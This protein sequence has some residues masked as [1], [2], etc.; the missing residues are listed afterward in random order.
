MSRSILAAFRR[1]NTFV[2]LVLIACVVAVLVLA[3]LRFYREIL[4]TQACQPQCYG[5]DALWCKE[6]GG[7]ASEPLNEGD[8]KPP[9]Y[10][11]EECDRVC[12]TT[13]VSAES[14][15]ANS[16]CFVCEDLRDEPAPVL[17]EEACP[18]GSSVSKDTCE[19]SCG[20]G[21][22]S[23]RMIS[24][25]DCF[26][27]LTCPAHTFSSQIL[28]E[29]SC[30][31]DCALAGAQGQLQ[32]WQCKPSCEELCRRNGMGTRTDFSVEILAE[33]NKWSCV[34]GAGIQENTA[35]LDGCTCTKPP[36]VIIDKQPFVCKGTPC[37]DVACNQQ[38]TCD[39]ETVT[40]E[41]GTV[42]QQATVN[43]A[44][45][46]WEKVGPNQFR[47]NIGNSQN[48]ASEVP[49]RRGGR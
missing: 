6:C 23:A 16:T 2:S 22:C 27:C 34:S 12:P 4:A 30:D 5:Y 36:S 14:G 19:K 43:C 1:G 8:C 15:G 38:K 24:G 10:S 11:A 3:L 44:W 49:A 21:T 40:N 9:L 37:G 45:G 31:A 41:S 35:A 33:L 17:P 13:C 28:C 32:C 18:E 29:A 48:A 39:V 46:G 25:V 26:E 7:G 47:I 42:T 20:N